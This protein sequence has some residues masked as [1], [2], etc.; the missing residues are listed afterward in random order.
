MENFTENPCSETSSTSS[1]E[2]MSARDLVYRSGRHF[3]RKQIDSVTRPEKPQRK[4]TEFR[5]CQIQMYSFVIEGNE[6][7][8]PETTVLDLQPIYVPSWPVL[9]SSDDKPEKIYL[10]DFLPDEHLDALL[11]FPFT[12][13]IRSNV[14][15]FIYNR[16][17]IEVNDS[18]FEYRIPMIGTQAEVYGYYPNGSCPTLPFGKKGT[19][20]YISYKKLFE[21]TWPSAFVGYQQVE[22]N[23]R[24]IEEPFLHIDRSTQFV[25]I[26]GEGIIVVTF[27]TERSLHQIAVR[28]SFYD[29]FCFVHLWDLQW[30]ENPSVL[31]TTPESKFYS[32]S[33]SFI[34]PTKVHVE[35]LSDNDI[36]QL[37]FSYGKKNN[38]DAREVM[39]WREMFKR[40]Y[41]EIEI[42][43]NL[44]YLG[45]PEWYCLAQMNRIHLPQPSS[46]P[47]ERPRVEIQM[48]LFSN[49]MP[50]IPGTTKDENL[51][52][53]QS[54][55]SVG[56][57]AETINR[58]S[59]SLDSSL[60]DPTSNIYALFMK[61]SKVAKYTD[62]ILSAAIDFVI[63]PYTTIKNILTNWSLEFDATDLT[64]MDSIW[65]SLGY[66]GIVGLAYHFHNAHP[67]ISSGFLLIANYH[68]IRQ[69]T[70]SASNHFKLAVALTVATVGLIQLPQSQSSSIEIQ[71]EIS[72]LSMAAAFASTIGVAA[73]GAATY[74]SFSDIF[75]FTSNTMKPF[76]MTARGL[77]FIALAFEY[78]G[79]LI[80]NIIVYL[81]GTNCIW[82]A[83]SKGSVSDIEM[84]EYIEYSLTR[85]PDDIT[86]TIAL[87]PAE[88]T[89]WEKMCRL[90]NSFISL[91]ASAK[92]RP[93]LSHIGYTMYNKAFSSFKELLEEYQKARGATTMFRPEPF[94][95]WMYGEPGVGKT[96]VRDSIANNLYVWHREL[97]PELPTAAET[98]MLYVRNPGDNYWTSFGTTR[99]SP[100]ATGWDDVGQSLKATNT[101]FDEIMACASTNINTLNMADLKDKGRKFNSRVMI[102]CANTIDPYTNDLV[103]SRKAINRRRHIVLEVVRPKIDATSVKSSKCDFTLLKLIVRDNEDSTKIIKTFPEQFP[104]NEFP[105][106]KKE[107]GTTEDVW[108]QFYK[109]LQPLYT[110]HVKEQ[111]GIVRSKE[112]E[113]MKVLHPDLFALAELTSQDPDIVSAL[114]IVREN[115]DDQI[116]EENFR[117]KYQ[118][119]FNKAPSEV[120]LKWIKTPLPEK[121]SL[122]NE[123]KSKI[124][125]CIEHLRLNTPNVKKG[126]IILLGL[127]STIAASVGVYKMFNKF[128]GNKKPVMQAY[129]TNTRFAPRGKTAIIQQ[130]VM[131]LTGT[132]DV[133]TL[134][135]EVEE[136][137]KNPP[138][139]NTW[140]MVS[141]KAAFFMCPMGGFLKNLPEDLTGWELR[142][143]YHMAKV[144]VKQN[145]QGLELGEYNE[146]AKI[147]RINVYLPPD[148]IDGMPE[149]QSSLTDLFTIYEKSLFMMSAVNSSTSYRR[150][151]AVNVRGRFFLVPFHF[152]QSI[153]TETQIQLTHSTIPTRNVNIIPQDIHRIDKTDWCILHIHGM[154]EG[155]DILNHFATRDELKSVLTFDAM[156][157]SYGR[158]LDNKRLTH[159]YVGDAKRFDKAVSGYVEG[160]EVVHPTGYA[161]HFHA[162]SGMCGSLLVA[163]DSTIRSRI[164]GMHFAYTESL[165]EAYAS[166]ISRERLVDICNEIVPPQKQ[167]FIDSPPAIQ[168][169]F[170]NKAPEFIG[171]FGDPLFECIGYVSNAPSQPRRHRDLFRSPS[172]N[173]VYPA[174]K[175]LSVL[176][177]NDNRLL[178]NLKGLP[179]MLNRNII[180]YSTPTCEWPRTELTLAKS[181]LLEVFNTF[182]ETTK[183]EVKSL[184][185]AI[186]GEWIGDSR[187]EHA[188]ALR[189]ETSAGYGFPGKKSIY[190]D[191]SDPKNIRISDVRLQQEVDTLWTQWKA[192]KSTGLVWTNALKSEPL[193]LSKIETGKTRTFCVCPTSGLLAIRRLFGAWTVA[194]K[195]SMIR[196]F[197]C[198]GMDVRSSDWSYLYSELRKVGPN[199][200]DMDFFNYDRIAVI[201]QLVD[202]ICDSINEWYNDGEEFARMRKIAIH[203]MI[204]SFM[205]SGDLMIRKFQG[206]PSG[207]P[208]TTELN[209]CA[210]LLMF[211]I[212]YLIIARSRSPDDYSV[213]SFK[214]NV[215]IK[216]YGDDVII[217][218]SP[219]CQLW[220]DVSLITP[221]YALHGITVT[222]ADKTSELGIKPLE[223]LTFLKCNFVPSGIPTHPWNAGLSK[224]S[225][226]N[227]MQF[228]RLQPN[229]GTPEEAI[230]HNFV[231]SCEYAYFWGEDYF[232]AHKR[233]CNEWINNNPSERIDLISLTYDELDVRYRIKLGI[234]EPKSL[235][236]PQELEKLLKIC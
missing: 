4:T 187:L 111:Q 226:E 11:E 68:L 219:S 51:S 24:E 227:M 132:P 75:K 78:I 72:P 152:V 86:T 106:D 223:E 191:T 99:G 146:H 58:L 70:S 13:P 110:E 122:S 59:S 71:S 151:H 196:T 150:V 54:I 21:K 1:I 222:P 192:G 144:F 203:E 26:P 35:T 15:N 95:F 36:W 197:S 118:A 176:T 93:S 139:R 175:D 62:E 23:L 164:M 228:Y 117:L 210:N 63:D 166:L 181:Y 69:L 212:V 124:K 123:T 74:G 211:I 112:L 137:T 201:M 67:V 105:Y 157:I 233:K 40:S 79:T 7:Q 220:F 154:P 208:L 182:R 65:L 234:D 141:V 215:C 217:T 49:L 128:F 97:E 115:P 102:L 73:A 19:L 18:G 33:K 55:K 235:L 47:E 133:E 170:I 167:F 41:E 165:R 125:E 53:S 8:P 38:P 32:P 2:Y 209:N 94:I 202:A 225:I 100:F 48:G 108:A 221:L 44:I 88:R 204:F 52:V 57:L 87:D 218:L 149:L 39:V 98:G 174:A 172:W 147:R 232:E 82:L 34:L 83:L 179:T 126:G 185:W 200:I 45:Y 198:L 113:L 27:Q 20:Q 3:D 42:F 148:V 189:L 28:M 162:V 120:I 199:G 231:E 155:R 207:N 135:A 109:W 214:K 230:S 90:H 224:T 17:H 213:R 130:K 80:N 84:Q 169:Q 116:V 92:T 173:E 142:L 206:N 10:N 178:D 77:P 6:V 171:E 190:F 140:R 119:H 43:N 107:F 216:T 64:I 168:C 66:A 104:E 156:L 121:F 103:L 236:S 177:H 183:R 195:N 101:E 184:H 193:K 134:K 131:E 138:P 229:N 145:R 30:V 136:S 186:N 114:Q 14:N 9:L 31:L 160:K 50:G 89:L 5:C 143:A 127:T 81:F 25:P 22:E 158:D 159:S 46:V 161:Y 194:M 163:V 153:K 129:D 56:K 91:F 205:L 188:E 180:G 96:L 16:S 29:F 12:I 61:L 37:I 60:S 76:V 85:S